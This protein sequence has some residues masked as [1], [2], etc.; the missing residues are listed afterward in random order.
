MKDAA[1]TNELDREID[2]DNAHNKLYYKFYNLQTSTKLNY[3]IREWKCMP[4]SHLPGY[5]YLRN[6]K[7][8]KM[9]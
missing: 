4:V 9:T 2:I 3:K 6:N 5:N 8:C 1:I 7:M